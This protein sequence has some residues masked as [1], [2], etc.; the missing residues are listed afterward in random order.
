MQYLTCTVSQLVLTNNLTGVNKALKISSSIIGVVK[1]E[2]LNNGI[3]EQEDINLI[4]LR[5]T[6]QNDD[7]GV[8]NSRE[9][10]LRRLTC[11]LIH[12]DIFEVTTGITSSRC[13]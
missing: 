11:L 2:C 12:L 1:I 13:I 4:G 6:C 5:Q 3:L 7:R 10:N 9:V 8:G